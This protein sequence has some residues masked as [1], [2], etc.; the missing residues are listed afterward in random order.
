MSAANT[1][2]RFAEA[3]A[4]RFSLAHAHEPDALARVM[5]KTAEYRAPSPSALE[6]ALFYDHPSI[7][8]RILA[9]MQWKAAQDSV[10]PPQ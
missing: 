4:D 3:D 10:A 9:A 1:L 6:E 5:L 2:S 7:E 8:H